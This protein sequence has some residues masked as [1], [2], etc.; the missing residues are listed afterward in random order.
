MIKE[1]AFSF[2]KRHYF[3]DVSEMGNWQN[4]DN[5]TLMSLYDYDIYIQDYFVNN[6]TLAGFDGLLYMTD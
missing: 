3:Q 6:K 5:D 2:N 4:I 1:F